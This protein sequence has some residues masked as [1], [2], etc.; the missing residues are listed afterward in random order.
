MQEKYK[1]SWCGCEEMGYGVQD[2]KARVRPA[3]PVTLT[4]EK[5]IHVMCKECGTIVRSYIEHP[6][7]FSDK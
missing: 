7:K 6:E 5:I 2:G 3:K 4:G 1:C